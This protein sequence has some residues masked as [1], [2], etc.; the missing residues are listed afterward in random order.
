VGWIS[1]VSCC[2][3]AVRYVVAPQ[4]TGSNTSGMPRRYAA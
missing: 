1:A 4:P 3:V 2:A